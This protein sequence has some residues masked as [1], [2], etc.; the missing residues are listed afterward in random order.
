MP[1]VGAATALIVA[2]RIAE[3]MEQSFDE[4]TRKDARKLLALSSKGGDIVYILLAAL[5]GPLLTIAYSTQGAPFATP[6]T[7]VGSI[8]LLFLGFAV[9]RRENARREFDALV[10]QDPEYW[11]PIMNKLRTI[12]LAAG[13]FEGSFPGQVTRIENSPQAMVG[14]ELSKADVP[15][16]GAVTLV[17]EKEI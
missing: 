4:E 12:I 2:R 3:A 17:A 15:Q 13:N 1:S 10:S 16:N 11:L 9:K 6:T 14:G 5:V 7:I 8:S